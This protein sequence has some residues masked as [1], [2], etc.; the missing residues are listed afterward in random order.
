MGVENQEAALRDA[1]WKKLL[2]QCDLLDSMRSAIHAS[3]SLSTQ[4][5]EWGASEIC[6]GN[7]PPWIS[8]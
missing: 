8:A 6:L 2:L 1:A 5:T 4:P 3:S 7:L